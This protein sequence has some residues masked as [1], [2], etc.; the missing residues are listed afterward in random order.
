MCVGEVVAESV[1]CPLLWLCGMSGVECCHWQSRFFIL[2]DIPSDNLAAVFR[3]MLVSLKLLQDA[4][5]EI[6]QVSV[7]W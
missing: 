4:V 1:Y 7:W 2:V 6:E 3:V 5:Q